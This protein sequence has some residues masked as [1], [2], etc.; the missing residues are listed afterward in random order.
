[1]ADR[2]TRT[3]RY[4]V[5]GLRT[6]DYQ[7]PPALTPMPE[8]QTTEPEVVLP[9]SVALGKKLAKGAAIQTAGLPGDIA[10]LMERG[11]QPGYGT[12]KQLEEMPGTSADIARRMD[13]D[14]DSPEFAASGFLAPVPPIGKIAALADKIGM[15]LPALSGILIRSG[16]KAI[17]KA[18]KM[19][20]AGKT[21]E[22]I[23]NALGVYRAPDPT[24]KGP[25][26][27]EISD[28][29]MKIKTEKLKTLEEV[30]K[31]DLKIDYKGY[32]GGDTFSAYGKAEDVVDH[33]QL[34]KE[35]PE[36]KEVII[37]VD[38]YDDYVKGSYK[39]E[40]IKIKPKGGEVFGSDIPFETTKNVV[41]VT[42]PTKHQKVYEAQKVLGN[43]RA[44]YEEFNRH[45][46]DKKDLLRLSI[47]QE[48]ANKI[49]MMSAKEVHDEA[50]RIN[51][52]T[53]VI[54]DRTNL[55]HKIVDLHLDYLEAK[56]LGDSLK[57]QTDLIEDLKKG[58]EPAFTPE[59]ESTM[60]HELQHGV[61]HIEDLPKGGSPAAAKYT[62]EEAIR[63]ATAKKA[64]KETAKLYRQDMA[65]NDLMEEVQVLNDLQ[66]LQ[67]LQK[68]IY[69]DNPTRNARFIRNNGI[70]QTS[71]QAKKI[72]SPPKRHKKFEYGEWLRSAA[73]NI[74]N[75][76]ISKYTRLRAG[77][78]PSLL[79]QR[80]NLDS[81]DSERMLRAS[82]KVMLDR[83]QDSGS[84]ADRLRF[85][86]E[87]YRKQQ[88][89]LNKDID[90][91]WI[92]YMNDQ[93][94]AAERAAERAKYDGS[95]NPFRMATKQESA[96]GIDFLEIPENKVKNA[97]DRRRRQ[98]DKLS[99]DA[100][101]YQDMERKIEKLH[102][103]FQEN[104]YTE[105]DTYMRYAGEAEARLVQSRRDLG[106]EA[107]EF[108]K[109]KN[110]K[111]SQQFTAED[112]ATQL[113]T[114]GYDVPVEELYYIPQKNP[115]RKIKSELAAERIMEEALP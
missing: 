81:M 102:K 1:M 11:M 84:K 88:E 15:T 28:V 48:D 83:L 108:R 44:E 97:I 22:E 29:P 2:S 21:P 112:L 80:Y 99:K 57:A 95:L 18:E 73:R 36:L 23:W 66:Y 94:N 17:A 12:T 96:I 72:G 3:D 105:Y 5:P 33:P 101:A 38:P 107:E 113:P 78:E 50:R 87:T 115:V 69:S 7:D 4:V 54:I 91:N 47:G 90:P 8:G 10:Y 58:K 52:E 79:Q 37:Q 74:Q 30:I 85:E 100:R 64:G 106:L 6:P 63:Y 35:M 110:I 39:Q 27:S 53:P 86:K 59:M 109:Q 62:A 42:G 51:K 75:E 82:D 46:S 9:A 14:P 111:R 41:T 25:W 71:D 19:E 70:L 76:I 68:F 60:V 92:D 89:A 104:N 45:I 49:R 55:E 26:L 77:D 103:D 43:R 32:T 114:K 56:R 24:D 34:F 93:I 40:S 65:Y 16:S 67:K 20:E 31:D 13:V 61:Q 98:M